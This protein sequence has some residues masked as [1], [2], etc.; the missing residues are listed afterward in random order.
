MPVELILTT[1]DTKLISH[2]IH[3]L[4]LTLPN[5]FHTSVNVVMEL[6]NTKHRV[7]MSMLKKA[8]I[9]ISLSLLIVKLFFCRM[10]IDDCI[11]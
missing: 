1:M 2:S 5:N 3:V 10:T 4:L 9:G 6:L 11:C 8:I 7:A